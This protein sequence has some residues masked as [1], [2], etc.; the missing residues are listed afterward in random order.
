MPLHPGG[1]CGGTGGGE[2]GSA[3][4]GGDGGSGAPPGRARGRRGDGGAGGGGGYYGGG[5]GG[6]GS[7]GGVLC[8][9]GGGGGGGSSF[10]AHGTLTATP[11][12]APASL[13]I[14]W[15]L[16]APS[17][18]ITAP[19][20]GATYTRNQVVNASY[21]CADDPNGPGI[22]SCTGTVADGSPIDTASAGAHSFSVTATASDGRSSTVTVNYTVAKAAPT[23]TTNASAN[24]VLGG[25]V[26]DTATLAGG[27][28]PGGQITFNLYGPDDANCSGTPAF[29]DTKA[30]SGDGSY[31]SADFIPTQAGVYRWTAAYS[32]DS[33]NDSAS[34]PCNAANESV[35]V[36]KAAPT[37]TTNASANVVLGGPVHD[38]A[39][40]AGGS[41]PGGQ[42]TFNLYG[43]DDANCSGTPAFTDTKAVSG[44]GSYDSA[45]F[46]PTQAGVYRWTAAYSGDSNNDSASSPCNA[47]N[48]SVTVAKAAPTLT[49]NASANVVLGGPVHDTATLAGGSSPG[50]Q[51]TFN[52][53]GPDDANC[54]GTPAF[55]DTK[56]V[57]GDGSYDSAD[58]IPTQAGVYRWTAAYSGDS[59][60]NSAAGACNDSGESVT[61]SVAAQAVNPAVSALHLAPA[62]F[63][64]SSKP[65]GLGPPSPKRGTTGTDIRF[66][67]SADALVRF[68]IR[69]VRRGP[70]APHAFKHPHTFNR[71]LHAGEQSI[72][73]TGTLNRRTLHPAKYRL[74]VR[75]IDT[76]TGYRSPKV[77]AAFTILGG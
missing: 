15:T 4:Q 76:T 39:T 32:G 37:L 58:F 16:P 55:T 46:I 8:G 44:D 13:A 77:S 33:N 19:A 20:D 51:I 52:L 30:V 21:S 53:Y 38:T 70:K 43:P 40:L 29:T 56:A 24:V 10:V 42:I 62:S 48:E 23:L 67:L 36:A 2:S 17:A 57:S 14:S 9:G 31:D 25:P 60:N 75:A 59:N 50:G 5:G 72:H 18:T 28:S 73:F 6:G 47:A 22:Q 11:T 64:A 69:P 3:G 27:S 45:D 1:P 68:S 49:T 63:A 34:S 41:S 7:R 74:H 26:H 71:D 61:V 66:T 54:S 12:S 35:T 65:T